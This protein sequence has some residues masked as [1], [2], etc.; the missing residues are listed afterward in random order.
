MKARPAKSANF[1]IRK[2]SAKDRLEPKKR[3]SIPIMISGMRKPISPCI[4]ATL[5]VISSR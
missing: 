1:Q 5:T 4:V 3:V 2:P